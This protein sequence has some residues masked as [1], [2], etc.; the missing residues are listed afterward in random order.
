MIATMRETTRNEVG[1][2]ED[3][4]EPEWLAN[5]DIGWLAANYETLDRF[6]RSFDRGTSG[7]ETAARNASRDS[8]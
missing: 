1:N 4:P 5:L 7:T 3:P 8:S 2:I 6:R